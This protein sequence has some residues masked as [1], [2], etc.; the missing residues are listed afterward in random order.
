[1]KT[2]RIVLARFKRNCYITAVQKGV[3]K[4]SFIYGGI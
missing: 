4:H 2:D 1:M 3:R